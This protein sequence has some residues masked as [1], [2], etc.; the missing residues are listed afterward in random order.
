[1]A[2]GSRCR[3][4][5]SGD[6]GALAQI[7]E[8]DLIDACLPAL[9]DVAAGL[10]ADG[11]DVGWPGYCVFGQISGWAG[12]RPMESTR[13]GRGTVFL[14]KSQAGPPPTQPTCSS[15]HHACCL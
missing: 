12:S 3:G 4:N 15:A 2:T 8:V 14:V 13:A 5:P 10:S 7:L 9:H 11:V 1:M 6:G